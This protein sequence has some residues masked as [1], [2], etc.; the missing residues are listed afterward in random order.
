MAQ[1]VSRPRKPGVD[2]RSL[3]VTLVM[4]EEIPSQVFLQ[5]I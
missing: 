4:D 2:H 1:A 3:H 5:L